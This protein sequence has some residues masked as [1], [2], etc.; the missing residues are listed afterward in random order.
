L[1][2]RFRKIK[3]IR[4]RLLMI[5]ALAALV[6]VAATYAM[7]MTADSVLADYYDHFSEK[8]KDRNTKYVDQFQDYIDA[9]HLKSSDTRKIATFTRKHPSIS[10]SIYRS[11]ST[12]Y[13]SFVPDHPTSFDDTLN[14]S[15]SK[16]YTL[17]FKDAKAIAV[18]YGTDDYHASNIL[19]LI[20]LSIGFLLFLLV[21]LIAINREIKYIQLLRDEIGI[22]ETGNLDYEVTV[23]GRDELSELAAG[24]NGM[25]VSLR[26]QFKL[27]QDLLKANKDMV[28]SMSHD[29]RTPLTSILLYTEI[30][31]S[32]RWETEEQLYDYIDK[33]DQKTHRLKSLTDHLFEYALVSREDKGVNLSE[34]EN[35]EFLLYDI[36]SEAG[37]TLMQHGFNCDPDFHWDDSKISINQDYL[38]RIMDNIVSNICKYA[39]P[40][41]AVRI[42]VKTSGSQVVVMFQNTVST[43]RPAAPTESSGIGLRNIENMMQQMNGSSAVKTEHSIYTIA[44]NFP[45]AGT[46]LP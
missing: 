8:L 23:K 14:Q 12:I 4:T 33:I 7:L 34:P 9:N 13:D 24:L 19:S 15:I 20:I 32:H 39:D 44:L 18:L 26:D 5:I 22:L 30:L 3:S 40:E 36:L 29:I 10:V 37:A 45:L 41:K 25:R 21:V 6:A 1:K 11:N 46:V 28:T 31:K 38:G 43:S 17:K 27:E 2:I 16:T 35:A 42:I